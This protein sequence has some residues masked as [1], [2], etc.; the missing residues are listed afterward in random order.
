M[1]SHELRAEDVRAAN[2]MQEVAPATVEDDE[3]KEEAKAA[4]ASSPP[5]AAAAAGSF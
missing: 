3:K 1:C 5:S 4:S 2:F